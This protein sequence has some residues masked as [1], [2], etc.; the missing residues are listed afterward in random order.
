MKLTLRATLLTILAT[1]LLITVGAVGYSSHRNARFIA[2]DL[3]NQILEQT[4]CRIDHQL[5]AL[6][7]IANCQG[8]VDRQLMISG[9]LPANDFGTLAARWVEVMKVYSKLTFLSL[10]LEA[11][12]VEF[13]VR[14]QPDNRL[15]LGER[16]Q[17]ART[18]QWEHRDYGP[19][20]YPEKPFYTHPDHPKDDPR[21]QPW[22]VAARRA[23]RQTWPETY[24]LP[25]DD[26]GQ[27]IPG[28]TCATPIYRR[29]G[30]LLGVHGAGFDLYELCQFLKTLKT[31][32]HGYAFVV[33]VQADGGRRL[34]AHPDPAI[35]FRPTPASAERGTRSAEHGV[36]GSAGRSTGSC[37]GCLHR[38]RSLSR[39][40]GRDAPPVANGGK[41]PLLRAHG[42]A[43]RR[44]G[45]RQYRQ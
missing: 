22:Y 43:H 36:L 31:G 21:T 4:S 7:R 15:V 32:R 5:N 37:P 26:C 19:E 18:G 38:R 6:M 35:L 20:A 41:T 16:R 45:G 23:G 30:T 29:D 24:V 44:S 28:A 42:A 8:A 2:T 39:E 11:E 12:G 17:N 1:L 27:A 40:V 25:G 3:S 14:R 33:E 10:S 9:Q 34:I 13:S